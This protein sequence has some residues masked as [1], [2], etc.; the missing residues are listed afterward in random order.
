MAWLNLEKINTLASEPARC[1]PSDM[2]VEVDLRR[3]WVPEHDTQLYFTPL[4]ES[5]HFEHRLRYN[6][7]FA[8]RINEFIMM[9]E[10]DLID[11]LLIPL[12]HHPKVRDNS[13][14]IEAMQTMMMSC[15]CVGE[16]L[17]KTWRV[18][19]GC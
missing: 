12:L 15:F 5:L 7:L 6:Q 11:R 19:F 14:L 8:C 13:A 3:P 16:V 10:A 1:M 18:V 2:T 9:L 4:Y 17:R